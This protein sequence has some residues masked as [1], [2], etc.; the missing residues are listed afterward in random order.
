MSIGTVTSPITKLLNVYGKLWC[1]IQGIIKILNTSTLQVENQIQI[2]CDAKPI[3]H[4]AVLNNFVWISV[5][6]S[7]TIT[8]CNVNK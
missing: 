6:N 8:C 1:A 7:A 3:S 2:S 4:M 5:Q